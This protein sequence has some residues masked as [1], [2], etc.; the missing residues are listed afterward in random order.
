MPSVHQ[1][2]PRIDAPP[3]RRLQIRDA[4]ASRLPQGTSVHT[5]GGEPAMTRE[6]IGTSDADESRLCECTGG[7]YRCQR[8]PSPKLVQP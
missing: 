8:P 2:R 4:T 7:V 3:G 5:R 1:I 6:A